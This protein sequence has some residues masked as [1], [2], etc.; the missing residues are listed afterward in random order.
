M[1]NYYYVTTY[2]YIGK[3][4]GDVPM[5]VEKSRNENKILKSTIAYPIVN[6]F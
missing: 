2:T 6:S 1:A 5:S 4:D 3:R